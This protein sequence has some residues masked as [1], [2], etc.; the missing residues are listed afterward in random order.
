MILIKGPKEMKMTT[1]IMKQIKLMVNYVI[2]NTME[3]K[4]TMISNF[5]RIKP[6]KEKLMWS[7]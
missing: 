4:L 1:L 6:V 2:K 7:A 5:Q 3:K